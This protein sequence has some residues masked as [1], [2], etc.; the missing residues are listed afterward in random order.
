M[1]HAEYIP[2]TAP[3][4]H[5]YLQKTLPEKIRAK[6]TIEIVSERRRKDVLRGRFMKS[7]KRFRITRNKKNE[8]ATHRF[9]APDGYFFPRENLPAISPENPTGQKLHH[10]LPA[11]MHEK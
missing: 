7:M 4:G 2:R 10:I 6:E 5:M 8:I 1:E 11:R 3:I 9:L